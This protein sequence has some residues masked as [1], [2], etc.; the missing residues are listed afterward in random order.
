VDSAQGDLSS[1]AALYAQAIALHEQ[2]SGP[3]N[4]YLL[5]LT[6]GDRAEVTR[7]AGDMETSE[8]HLQQAL[9]LAKACVRSEQGNQLYRWVLARTY[10]R[11]GALQAARG[12]PDAAKQSYAEAQRLGQQVLEGEPVNKRY[13]L[14]LIQALLGLGMRA[15]GCTLV[16]EFR[17]RDGEDA[18]FQFP[19][20]QGARE[21]K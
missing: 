4:Q 19:E 7:Q 5:A 6:L 10:A 14:V 16:H 17:E 18:R 20:C 2:N 8:R 13:A 3:Y 11:L 1:A 15:E 9:Q 21:D 12:Q